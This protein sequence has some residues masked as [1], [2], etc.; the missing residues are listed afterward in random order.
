MYLCI[1]F[2]RCGPPHRTASYRGIS[3]QCDFALKQLSGASGIHDNEHN[4]RR[5]PANLKPKTSAT[6]GKQ[7]RRT[8]RTIPWPAADQTPA[9][10]AS[11]DA[12][13]KFDLSRNNSHPYRL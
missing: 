10:I 3:T 9:P 13:G 11:A 8:P 4:I 12:K 2:G 6:H 1:G 7:G 5:L